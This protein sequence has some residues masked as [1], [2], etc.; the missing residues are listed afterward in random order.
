[1]L[2]NLTI[3]RYLCFHKHRRTNLSAYLNIY[4]RESFFFLRG[5]QQSGLD[6]EMMIQKNLKGLERMEVLITSHMKVLFGSKYNSYLQTAR[7]AKLTSTRIVYEKTVMK[8]KVFRGVFRTNS[9]IYDEAF[10]RK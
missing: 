5:I 8:R 9:N 3:G 6:I 7:N 1:M 10:L 4:S 2:G